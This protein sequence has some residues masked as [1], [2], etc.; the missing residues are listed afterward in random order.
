MRLNVLN[1]VTYPTNHFSIFGGVDVADKFV[2]L[3]IMPLFP[4][5]KVFCESLNRSKEV[6]SCHSG[7]VHNFHEYTAGSLCELPWFITLVDSRGTV[8][9]DCGSGACRGTQYLN[10]SAPRTTWQITFHWISRGSVHPF[11]S[12]KWCLSFFELYVLAGNF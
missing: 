10:I 11:V 9:P 6:K 1:L 5:C 3:F 2:Q 8:P 4:F 12:Q 7:Y